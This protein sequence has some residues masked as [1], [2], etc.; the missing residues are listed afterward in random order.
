MTK[1]PYNWRRINMNY[2]L[3]LKNLILPRYLY[4]EQLNL[5]NYTSI[6]I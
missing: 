4:L 5:G 3:L 2:D 1:N 6:Q